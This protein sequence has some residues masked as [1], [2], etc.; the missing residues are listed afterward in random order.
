M[1]ASAP[2]TTGAGWAV[3][4]WPPAPPGPGV[5]HVWAATVGERGEELEALEATLAPDER[6]RAGRL[7]RPAD[8]V[9]YTVAHGILRRV[10]AGYLEV[11]PESLV[12]ASGSQGKP[13]LVP[14]AAAP[15]PDLRFNLSHSGDAVLVA[16]AIGCDVGV[17]IESPE[18]PLHA[19]TIAQRHFPPAEWEHLRPLPEPER[20]A[21]FLRSWVCKEAFAKGTGA[22][23]GGVALW[24]IACLPDAEGALGLVG[25]SV[26]SRRLLRGWAVVELPAFLGYPAALAVAGTSPDAC[27]WRF[28]VP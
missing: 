9:R 13:V 7:V 5:V 4:P 1:R 23:L 11:A 28:P 21:A 14:P 17:D 18:R 20:H 16:V 8:R 3:G 22:G 26:A 24:S 25:T 2:E 6:A 12:F 19:D 27:C 10:L 15:W